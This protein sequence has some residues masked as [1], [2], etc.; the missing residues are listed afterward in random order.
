MP[1]ERKFYEDLECVMAFTVNELKIP[2][3]KIFLWGYSL[4]SGPTVDLA[5]RYQNIAGVVIMAPLAS[6]LL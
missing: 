2:L 5:S 1:T 6:C 4:G 3:E